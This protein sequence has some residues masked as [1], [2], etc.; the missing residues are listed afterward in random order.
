MLND[1]TITARIVKPK[2]AVF[3]NKVFELKT[4]KGPWEAI[5]AIVDYWVSTNPKRYDSFIL[6]VKKK[7]DSRA[8]KYGS[9]KGKNIRSTLDVPAK[10]IEMI[11]IV[12][13]HDELPMDKKFF[14]EMWRRYP[15][16]RV[17]ERL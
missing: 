17:A 10:V 9:D 4:T 11:R 12:F 13:K 16:F 8:T 3:A 14:D 5:D 2:D 1:Q 7:R 6:E 15:T